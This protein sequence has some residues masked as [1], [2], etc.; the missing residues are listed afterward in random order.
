MLELPNTKN[1]SNA[2]A[3]I[4]D[5]RTIQCPDNANFIFRDLRQ[6]SVQIELRTS[7]KSVA[8][9]KFHVVTEGRTFRDSIKFDI[10]VP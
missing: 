6:I 1:V 3:T 7:P 10:L 8:I 5:V 4:T 2:I 9:K